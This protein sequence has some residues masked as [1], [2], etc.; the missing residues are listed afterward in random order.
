MT[1]PSRAPEFPHTHTSTVTHPSGSPIPPAAQANPLGL[2]LVTFLTPQIQ[3][4]PQPDG[5]AL[6]LPLTLLVQPT[7]RLLQQPHNWC[8]HLALLSC[9]AV[10]TQQHTC[11]PT[12]HT[13]TLLRTHALVF[14]V[15][16]T[17]SPSPHAPCSVP[18]QPQHTGSCV[19][20]VLPAASAQGLCAC[21]PT[22]LYL[23]PSVSRAYSFTSFGFLPRCPWIVGLPGRATAS[24]LPDPASAL[25]HPL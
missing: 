25:I 9:P 3:S 6:K 2:L 19:G 12:T 18:L 8:P 4:V 10:P 17:W 1:W 11:P 5:C 22:Y 15:A 24:A 21:F 20:L 23:F 16:R 14:A 13:H 7:L